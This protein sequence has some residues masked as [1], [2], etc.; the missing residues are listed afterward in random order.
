MYSGLPPSGGG[1][2]PRWSMPLPAQGR[3]RCCCCIE[4]CCFRLHLHKCQCGNLCHSRVSSLVAPT[5]FP[6]LGTFWVR[7]SVG[8]VVGVTDLWLPWLRTAASGSCQLQSGDDPHHLASL[9][10]AC[11][12]TLHGAPSMVTRDDGL[13]LNHVL[14]ESPLSKNVSKKCRMLCTSHAFF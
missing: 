9:A 14:P 6:N 13:L 3:C 4:G 10:T 12:P 1:P 8:L 2:R 11:S 7:I 5:A